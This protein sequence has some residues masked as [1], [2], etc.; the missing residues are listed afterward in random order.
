MTTAHDDHERT[1]APRPFTPA[2]L[3][4]T[5]ATLATGALLVPGHRPN[6]GARDREQPWIYCSATLDAAIWGAELADGDGTPRV[7]LV[8]ATGTL[9]DDPNLTDMKY[10]GNPS[11]SYRSRE[12]LRVVGEVTGWVGH[13]QE[14]IAAMRAGIARLAAEGHGPLD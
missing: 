2:Y 5:R 11:R 10:P 13:A 8:E 4:G 7:Y 12:A 6:F 9:E 3:H 1:G 14:T